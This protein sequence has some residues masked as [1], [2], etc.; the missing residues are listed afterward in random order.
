MGYVQGTGNFEAALP[1]ITNG[2]L[3]FYLFETKGYPKVELCLQDKHLTRSQDIFTESP[4]LTIFSDACPTGWGAVYKGNSTGGNWIREES[5]FHINTLG[6]AAALYA[7]KSL[8]EMYPTV[9][10]N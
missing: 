1:A 9:V 5:C 4:E 3:Q 2:D 6:M 7:L 8:S 10:L